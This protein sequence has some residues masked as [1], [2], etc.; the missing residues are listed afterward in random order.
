Y[1]HPSGGL[2]IC[3]TF[4]CLLDDGLLTINLL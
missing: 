3:P 1:N 2:T 4:N